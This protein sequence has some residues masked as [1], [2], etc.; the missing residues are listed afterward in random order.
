MFD[1]EDFD[2]DED[3]LNDIGRK[4][5]EYY[6]QRTESERNSPK[7]RKIVESEYPTDS[8]SDEEPDFAR[9]PSKSIEPVAGRS[10]SG[11]REVSQKIIT[12]NN[13]L[14]KSESFSKENNW[15]VIDAAKNTEKNL[16]VSVKS[17][18][19]E[20]AEISRKTLALEILKKGST[21]QDSDR[22]EK[23]LTASPTRPNPLT[24]IP[25][26]NEKNS[27]VNEEQKRR[28]ALLELFKKPYPKASKSS[29]KSGLTSWNASSATKPNAQV[30]KSS[31][32]E[33]NSQADD[34]GVQ[35]RRKSLLESFKKPYSKGSKSPNKFGEKPASTTYLPNDRLLAAPRLPLVRKFPGPAGLLPDC[36][37]FN[38]ETGNYLNCLEER[39][40]EMAKE[41]DPGITEY[42]SQNTEKLFSAG[43][44]QSMLDDLP[45][46][47]L[48]GHDI[49]TI[50]KT[51]KS[52]SRVSLLA[53]V[54]ARI[55]HSRQNPRLIL[56]DLSDS[57]EATMHPDIL[58]AHPSIF[59]PGVVVLLRHAGV[60]GFQT[61]PI[62]PTL[63]FHVMI[64]AKNI[65]AVY[66]EKTRIV[67]SP[68]M[69]SI[70]RNDGDTQISNKSPTRQIEN[71]SMDD[72][73][74]DMSGFESDE[75]DNLANFDIDDFTNSQITA[76]SAIFSSKKHAEIDKSEASNEIKGNVEQP[77]GN[78]SS[79]RDAEEFVTG[80]SSSAIRMDKNPSESRTKKM[81][82]FGSRTVQFG[83]SDDQRSQV[84]ENVGEPPRRSDERLLAPVE[85]HSQAENTSNS[86][87]FGDAL[88]DSDNDTEDEILSQ[89]DVDSILTSYNSKA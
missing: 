42:F 52:N 22:I 3:F 55:D 51:A 75:D 60:L 79:V 40:V 80:P 20:N 8:S 56:K 39:N 43:A 9:F 81:D 88:M 24:P 63:Q 23:I 67:T 35:N 5:E 31:F 47:F 69:E 28:E 37:D 70:L 17:G 65:V 89:L 72:D 66:S 14:R 30:E 34:S 78:P 27:R 73:D 87:G 25:A 36:P 86:R 48:R 62:F 6:S 61:S 12:T 44:W 1:G 50:K 32:N 83:S 19:I 10:E 13:D 57:I 2:L 64:A 7:R 38:F 4:E 59:E 77:G 41:D 15:N 68:W 85:E 11:N 54:I 29:S 58:L 49:A 46:G 82:E 76:N 21:T 33:K 84:G 74:I 18:S 53:G 45:S 26:S 71:F 16:Q